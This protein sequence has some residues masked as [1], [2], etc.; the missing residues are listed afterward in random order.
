[1]RLGQ[2]NWLL[3]AIENLK[4]AYLLFQ[5]ILISDVRLTNRIF[6]DK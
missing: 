5:R 6:S 4:F 2:T 1:M 3:R